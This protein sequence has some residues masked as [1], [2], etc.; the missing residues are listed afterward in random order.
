MANATFNAGIDYVK[1]ALKIS[2]DDAII[3]TTDWM[4]GPIIK[5]RLRAGGVSPD[6]IKASA[7]QPI[8]DFK[9]QFGSSSSRALRARHK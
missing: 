2:V 4:I 3:K 6:D 9:R 1:H 5:R 8:D 7:R